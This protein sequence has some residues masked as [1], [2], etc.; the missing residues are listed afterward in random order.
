[1]IGG[2][3]FTYGN[4]IIKYEDHHKRGMRLLID[5]VE[6]AKATVCPILIGSNLKGKIGNKSV[7][8]FCKNFAI[9]Y[10]VELYIDEVLVEKKKYLV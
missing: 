1:M 8:V 7:R 2:V 9:Y 10:S 4:H 3:T 5:G 6:H